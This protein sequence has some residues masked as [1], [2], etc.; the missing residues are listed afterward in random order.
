MHICIYKEQMQK[1]EF[2]NVA[3]ACCRV[4]HRRRDGEDRGAGGEDGRAVAAQLGRP[5]AAGVRLRQ[6]LP[7]VP[8]AA[9]GPVPALRTPTAQRHPAVGPAR[10]GRRVV[11]GP[12][13]P[14]R[15]GS[16]VA[17]RQLGRDGVRRQRPGPLSLLSLQQRA[18]DAP[19]PLLHVPLLSHR[20][21][22]STLLRR[23]TPG[24]HSRLSGATPSDKH[25][26]TPSEKQVVGRNVVTSS[27]AQMINNQSYVYSSINAQIWYSM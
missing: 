6:L 7:D 11:S 20:C 24:S 4:G 2:K 14:D 9:G 17:P 18:G 25:V 27:A 12:G 21:R 3:V 13:R 10:R 8:R 22:R 16:D 15:V 26:A 5:T 23:L 19:R 1:H